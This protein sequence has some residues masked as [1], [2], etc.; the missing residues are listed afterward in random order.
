M[1]DFGFFS[2]NAATTTTA[3]PQNPSCMKDN[4]VYFRGNFLHHTIDHFYR[5]NSSMC[6]EL[7]E[8]N[9]RCQFW[10]YNR[11]GHRNRKMCFLM[12]RK[13]GDYA[14]TGY[15]SGSKYCH[16]VSSCFKIVVNNISLS[17]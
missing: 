5:P 10:T 9:R 3:S 6:Q 12:S 14:K 7:C 2:E 13:I 1:I 17:I 4:T 15:L 16:H 8:R 11:D